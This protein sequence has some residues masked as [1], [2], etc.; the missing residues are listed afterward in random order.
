[1]CVAVHWGG[2]QVRSVG[3]DNDRLFSL[4]VVYRGENG[5]ILERPFRTHDA[6]AD[7]YVLSKHIVNIIAC[8][9]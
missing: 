6:C 7:I 5:D 4:T 3:Y 2:G 9:S 1:M 8:I